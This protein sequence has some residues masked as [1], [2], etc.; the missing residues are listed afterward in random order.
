MCGA[1]VAVAGAFAV[2]VG[3]VANA[4]TVAGIVVTGPETEPA[5]TLGIIRGVAYP[6]YVATQWPKI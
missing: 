6:L 4:D 1:G 2:A 5:R 3:A